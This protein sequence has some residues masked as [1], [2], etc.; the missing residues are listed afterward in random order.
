MTY[1]TYI[2]DAFVC[3]SRRSNTSDCSYLLFTRALGMVYASARSVREERSK[4]RFSLQE[5][6]YIR[7]TLIQ[8]KSEWRITGVEPRSNVFMVQRTREA[9][10]F[11]RNIALLLRRIM[12]GQV[13]YSDIFD[14]VEKAFDIPSLGVRNYAYG[15][16][17]LSLRILHTLGYVTPHPHV[18]AILEANGIERA[19]NIIT[20]EMYTF[21][22]KVI[23]EALSE[24][25]L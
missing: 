4:Q 15:E 21:G 11:V 9:R 3:G 17:A 18:S 6:S 8:G 20:P 25:H 1:Q 23:S 22:L 14:D 16:C 7:V 13:A 2:T 10:A 12:Q 5:F 19:E 24:S